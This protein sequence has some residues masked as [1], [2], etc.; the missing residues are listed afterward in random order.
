MRRISLITE[1][2]LAFQ[3]GLCPREYYI[4]RTI[5]RKLRQEYTIRDT[6][7]F[8]KWPI[9]RHEKYVEFN[10][11]QS[12]IFLRPTDVQYHI[13]KEAHIP[14]R[15][16][17]RFPAPNGEFSIPNNFAS[18]ATESTVL[19][20]SFKRVTTLMFA[21]TEVVIRFQMVFVKFSQ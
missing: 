6:S 11:T 5:G 21:G 15:N 20:L 9:E 3:E 17:A 13:E 12:E 10:Q 4:T 7:Q 18:V 1:D 19:P 2:L 16:I 14:R 8:N